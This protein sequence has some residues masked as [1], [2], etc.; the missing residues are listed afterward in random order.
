MELTKTLLLAG[1]LALSAGTASAATCDAGTVFYELTQDGGTPTTASCGSGNDEGANG[2]GTLNG[3]DLADTS[4]ADDPGDGFD[5]IISGNMWSI[6]GGDGYDAIAVAF[7]QATTYAFFLLDLS[8]PL[9]GMWSI[10]GPSDSVQ[11]YSHANGWTKGE[12]SEVPI[13]ASA[14]LLIGGLGGL[15]AVRRLKKA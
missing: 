1:A 5:L 4:D 6:T 3:W 14:F 9:T 2:F 13:P 8:A 15:A 7:K 10:S 11:V 12:P